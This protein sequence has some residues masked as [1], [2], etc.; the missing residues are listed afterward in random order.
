M[1]ER[2]QLAALAPCTSASP[3][4]AE[5]AN[6]EM[7]SLKPRQTCHISSPCV[8]YSS[9]TLAAL[10]CLGCFRHTRSSLGRWEGWFFSNVWQTTLQLETVS[11]EVTCAFGFWTYKSKTGLSYPSLASVKFTELKWATLMYFL[12]SKHFPLTMVFHTHSISSLYCVPR[13][14]AMIQMPC[15]KNHFLSSLLQTTHNSIE[16]EELQGSSKTVER[17]Y[18][19]KVFHLSKS[20]GRPM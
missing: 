19:N 2:H 6:W 20:T 12:L 5:H 15:L 18:L 4:E 1:S 11:A 16:R 17:K 8:N 3:T 13:T 7:V 9:L 10:V 14:P